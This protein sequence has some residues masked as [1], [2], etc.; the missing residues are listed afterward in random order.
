MK[1][2]Y[3]QYVETNDFE[4]AVER[5]ETATKRYSDYWWECVV[6]IFNKGAEWAK[7]YIIDPIAKTVKKLLTRRSLPKHKEL[8]EIPPGN[9][10]YIITLVD[11]E[12]QRV[13]DKIGTTKNIARRMQEHLYNKVYKNAGVTDFILK[14][15][16]DISAYNFDIIELESKIRT[17]LRKKLGDDKYLKNDRFTCEI[18][19]NDLETKIPGCVQKLQE[20]EI[21]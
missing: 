15:Y 9:Y 8:D 4:G 7:K 10:L 3:K 16:I 11:K 20:A 2:S 14:K 21:A 6:E 17:Y 1:K 13:W 18:D 12:N 19:V 5:Y